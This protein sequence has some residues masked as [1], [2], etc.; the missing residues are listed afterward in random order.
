MYIMKI[1]LEPDYLSVRLRVNAS[2]LF[3]YLLFMEF[4]NSELFCCMCSLTEMPLYLLYL[5]ILGLSLFVKPN[6]FI[7]Y[8]FLYEAASKTQCLS[9]ITMF[10]L[11]TILIYVY[12]IEN[13]IC[14]IYIPYP[15]YTIFA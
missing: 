12:H 2:W 13:F 4:G 3:Y 5:P 15:L 1:E 11:Y 8:I 6:A 14:H 9:Y 7:Y 10:T